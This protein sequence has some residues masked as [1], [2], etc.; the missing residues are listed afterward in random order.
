MSNKYI[1]ELL[2][3]IDCK[4]EILPEEHNGF[5]LSLMVVSSYVIQADGKIMHSEMEFVR[6]FLLEHFGQEK[7][8]KY[9]RILLQLF[10]KSKQNA[11]EAWTA[12]IENCVREM[13]HYTTEEQ[14]ML[15][16]SFLIKI[17]KADGN[18]DYMEVETL[19]NVA[20]WLEIELR[21]SDTIE[22]L[23]NNTSWSWVL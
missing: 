10:E 13:N 11:P 4:S 1:D 21:A 6:N 8:E 20:H 23:Y 22:T 3:A 19:K 2:T 9:A 18:V 16:L 7:K 15:M 12:K 17:V 14:R 5:L